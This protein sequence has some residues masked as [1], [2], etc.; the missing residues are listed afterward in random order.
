M[1]TNNNN[2]PKLPANPPALLIAGSRPSSL[3]QVAE[4]KE[5]EQ[6]E[7]ELE[8]VPPEEDPLSKSTIRL[9][10]YTKWLMAATLVSIFCT[11]VYRKPYSS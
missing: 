1:T 4:E 11:C 7:P 2:D 9:E 10:R 8:A 5:V 6:P 3:E